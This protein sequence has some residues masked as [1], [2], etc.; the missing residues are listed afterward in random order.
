MIS[1][2]VIGD[3]F[4]GS[5]DIANVLARA[6]AHTV[7][8]AGL[9]DRPLETQADAVVV[10]LKTRSIPAAEAVEQ[11][12]QACR[13]LVE[14]G[15]AQIFFKYCSTFDS[16]PAGNIGPVIAALLDELGAPLALACPAF[17]ANGRT[18]Y[19]G[20]LFVGDRLL[21][22]SGMEKHPLNPM[23]DPDIRRWLRRQTAMAVG[24]LPL[25]AVRAGESE[26]T[27]EA[28]QAR[29]DRIVIADAVIDDDLLALGRAVRSHRLVTG[30]SALA[31]GL[32]GNF[33]IGA[34]DEAAASFPGFTGP[35]VLLSGSCSNATRRQVEVYAAARPA[36]RI[37]GAAALD[38]ER[39]LADAMRFVAENIDSAPLV[40]SS[41]APD[42]V[43]EMQDRYGQE[44]L[45]AA[46]DRLFAAIAV[47]SVRRGVR[48][49]V[50][51]G[52]E[53]SGAVTS[54]FGSFAYA[55]GPEIAPGVPVL[56]SEREPCMALALKSGNFGD[57]AFFEKALRIM[58]GRS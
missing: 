56:Y 57:D 51:A 7:Q 32:P 15:A 19:Q 49:L 47:E 34:G 13:W 5:S 4:T 23:T 43:A 50:V 10:A 41:A 46:L 21:S 52:G 22:E 27:L 53:T 11:S 33:G 9:P 42:A 8:L 1:I 14:H 44:R 30:G 26:R 39:A 29:G 48:R 35:A 18:V 36:L 45:A 58:E 54:A 37:D 2:G 20:H 16:T 28:A 12:L 24:H 55:V 31:G 38:F 17:P 40:Y 25:A 6:G 3:D